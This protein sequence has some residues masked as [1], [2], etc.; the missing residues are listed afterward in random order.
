MNAL[1]AS[2]GP[3]QLSACPRL[4]LAALAL[5]ALHAAR[6]GARHVYA[7]EANEEAAEAARAAVAE[8][9]FA[10]RVTVLDGYS[11]EVTL[12]EPVDLVVH[13]IFG[14]VAGA[15]GVVAAIADAAARHMVPLPS[16]E[17]S[18]RPLSVPARARSLVA[19]AE[20][21]PA[22]YFESLPL[23]MISAPGATV[24][25]LPGLP[26]SLLLAPAATFE[27]LDFAAAA[28]HAAHDV[29]L[30]FVAV[31]DG[32]LR[33]LLVH[34]ELEMSARAAPT[35]SGGGSGEAD[36]AENEPDVSSAR[37]GSHW[38]NVFLLLPEPADVTAGTRVL[39]SASAR[40]GGEKP[41]YNFHVSLLEEGAA[42][43]RELGSV[44]YP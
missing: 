1:A 33:G 26:R 28:P 29:S 35:Q 7:V 31:R 30:S 2:C 6:A 18:A 37:P 38:P 41:S 8:A 4:A 32:L 5:L 22:A 34:I 43:P 9:G 36:E 21:P 44:G 15:E 39:V 16:A 23:P 3:V 14:E 20:F 11:T 17:P 19:P 40:L 42:E 24:L 12:P 13:E 25:K 10:D 27:D